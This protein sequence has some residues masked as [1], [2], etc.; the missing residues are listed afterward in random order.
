MALGV[1]GVCAAGALAA[2]GSTVAVL[3]CGLSV[4][5]PKEHKRLMRAIAKYGAVVTEYP[6][7]ERPTGINFPKRNRIISGLSQGTLIVEAPMKSGAL[8]TAR[9]AILQGREV[10]A[11]PGNVDAAS[12]AGTNALIRDGATAVTCASPMRTAVFWRARSIRGIRRAP[13]LSG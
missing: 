12:A 5:Y 10:F 11:L 1:D 9:D 2:G 6:L 3:G 13:R 4:V 7:T 8:I